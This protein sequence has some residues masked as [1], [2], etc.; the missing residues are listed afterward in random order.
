MRQFYKGKIEKLYTCDE[1][2][3]G[4]IADVIFDDE[5]AKKLRANQIKKVNKLKNIEN[6]SIPRSD[7]RKVNSLYFLMRYST[8]VGSFDSEAGHLVT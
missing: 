5:R 1:N 8:P 4:F 6:S 3:T 7:I 2:D